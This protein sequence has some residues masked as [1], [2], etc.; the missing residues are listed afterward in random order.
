MSPR[1]IILD[2]GESFGIN[3][4][5]LLD[6]MLK[7]QMSLTLVMTLLTMRAMKK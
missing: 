2:K 1:P 5:D 4:G 7:G 6:D 3:A